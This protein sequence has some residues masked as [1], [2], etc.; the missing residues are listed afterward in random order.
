[1]CLFCKIANK[2]I[3][4]KFIYEDKEIIAFH[5]IS[6]VAPFHILIIP[7]QHIQDINDINKKNANII[8]KMMLVAKKISKEQNIENK[9]Y[10]LII[11]TGEQ[12]GQTVFHLHMHMIANRTL[13][14]PP[15]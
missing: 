7:K 1:M 11:N 8:A 2:E 9:S 3:P 13:N 12:A 10:R 6:P 15:G 14:W 4:A 5:D